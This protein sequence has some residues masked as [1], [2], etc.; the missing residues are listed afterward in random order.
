MTK[1]STLANPHAGGGVEKTT[2]PSGS[3]SSPDS[4][5]SADSQPSYGTNDTKIKAQ[6]TVVT[7]TDDTRDDSGS[8]TAG[9]NPFSDPD[10]AERYRLVY[11]RAHY[12]C[13][14]VFDPQLTWTPEEE[15]QLLRRIDWR[16]CL[17]A[18][19]TRK[20]SLQDM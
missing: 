3:R 9:E 13:R 18:V 10:V 2:V 5:N 19:R 4:I 7:S 14:H 8:G 11:E 15:K 6:P 1:D 17:W 20:I 12:E 16:V